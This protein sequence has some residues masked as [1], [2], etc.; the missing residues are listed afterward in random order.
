MSR[1]HKPLMHQGV[2][3]PPTVAVSAFEAWEDDNG[4][5]HVLGTHDRE[6][7]WAAVEAWA[8][9]SGESLDGA[10]PR[11]LALAWVIESEPDYFALVPAG[12]PDAIQVTTLFV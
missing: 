1:K 9:E 4:D 7:A 3:A 5:V 11:D 12:T 8:A 2:A 10:G 6:Q